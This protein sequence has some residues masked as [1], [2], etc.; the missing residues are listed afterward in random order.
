MRA[1]VLIL[2]LFV[3]ASCSGH[4]S[5]LVDIFDQIATSK[6][7]DYFDLTSQ[8]KTALK[9]DIQ[10][11]VDSIRKNLFPKMSKEMEKTAAMVDQS[12]FTPEMAAERYTVIQDQMKKLVHSFKATALKATSDLSPEQLK[13]FEKQTKKDLDKIQQA[14]SDS[15]RSQKTLFDKYRRSLKFWMGPLN[16]SQEKKLYQFVESNPY[17]WKLEVQSKEQSLKEFLKSYEKPAERKA[18]VEKYFDDFESIRSPEYKT[19][20]DAHK[21]AFRQ[22]F[23]TELWPTLTSKQKETFKENLEDRATQIQKISQR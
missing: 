20:L 11:D 15:E 19:A 16:E 3:L 8:Q 6:V 17:P 23:S 22:F 7:D 5:F 12:Q 2:S 14:N 18:F 9:K 4:T 21:K 1:L 13:Y 10:K